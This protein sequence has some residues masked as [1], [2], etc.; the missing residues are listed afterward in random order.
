MPP[1]DADLPFRL[2]RR[3]GILLC[4]FSRPHNHEIIT[5]PLEKR[6]TALR[7]ADLVE[8]EGAD[9]RIVSAPVQFFNQYLIVDGTGISDRLF[10]DLS[11]SKSIGSILGNISQRTAK[12]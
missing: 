3:S 1:H 8:T 4:A 7:S 9:Y 10:Q 11:H 6:E 12:H 2:G 5:L